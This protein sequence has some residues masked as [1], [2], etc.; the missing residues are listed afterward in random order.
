MCSST[1]LHTVSTRRVLRGN[2]KNADQSTHNKIIRKPLFLTDL[3]LNSHNV[4]TN[5]GSVEQLSYKFLEHGTFPSLALTE[6]AAK[7]HILPEC[8]VPWT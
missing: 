2:L 1:L 5:N 6:R 7:L 3:I 8:A 4:I